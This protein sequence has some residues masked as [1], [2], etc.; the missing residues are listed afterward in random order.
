[1]KKIMIAFIILVMTG[2]IAAGAVLRGKYVYID[3]KFHKKDVKELFV[4]LNPK[5]ISELNRCTELEFLMAADMD[6]DTLEQ[7]RAFEK[8][9]KLDISFSDS[10]ISGSGI[11]KI[12]M[13]PK[14][15]K[16]WFYNSEFDLSG[17]RNNSLESLLILSCD[18]TNAHLNEIKNCPSLNELRLSGV[19]MDNCFTVTEDKDYFW[20]RHALTDSSCLSELDTITKLWIYST[21]IEDISGIKDMDSLDTLTVDKGYISEEYKKALEDEGITVVEYIR[22]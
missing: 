6:N 10:K 17:I 12:N 22:E 4:S 9:K 2:G 19:T 21:F 20:G 11:E 13:L 15:N 14:L 8:L 5:N 7:M 1:M 18:I 3:G 16:L